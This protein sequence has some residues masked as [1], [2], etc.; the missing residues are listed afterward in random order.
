MHTLVHELAD[1]FLANIGRVNNIQPGAGAAA[2][3]TLMSVRFRAY[4][5]YRKIDYL[6]QVVPYLVQ[7][8]VILRRML[9]VLLPLVIAAA[10]TGIY[11]G[12]GETQ[13]APVQW[14]LTLI[15]SHRDQAT[16]LA[17]IMAVSFL[18]WV[19]AEIMRR[20]ILK[21][22]DQALDFETY[23]IYDQGREIDSR[24]IYTFKPWTFDAS[25]VIA[26]Q[27]LD[28][29]ERQAPFPGQ[30]LPPAPVALPPSQPTGV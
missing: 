8:G 5:Y 19:L 10:L 20:T 15:D 29:L 12:I 2:A 11:F 3:F 26:L 9:T 6:R 22:I 17:G 7:S 23:G 4:M 21:R 27:M 30:P 18:P 24:G 28:L 25:A 16:I 13:R 1:P 14:V